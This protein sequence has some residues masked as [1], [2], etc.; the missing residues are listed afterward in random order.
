MHY[1]LLSPRQHWS[2]LG[3]AKRKAV[4]IDVSFFVSLPKVEIGL[5]TLEISYSRLRLE[6][7]TMVVMV[8]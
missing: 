2:C 4:F 7:D 5:R 1:T 3:R 8:N 6:T